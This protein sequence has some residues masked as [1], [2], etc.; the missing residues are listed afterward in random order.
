MLGQAGALTKCSIANT[1]DAVRKPDLHQVGAVV[2]G[3]DRNA[4]VVTELVQL[5]E[6]RCLRHDSIAVG[7]NY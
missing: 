6:Q 3:I 5:D 2:E 7:G 1:R 4:R